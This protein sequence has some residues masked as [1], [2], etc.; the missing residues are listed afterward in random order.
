MYFF[1]LTMLSVNGL[2]FRRETGYISRGFSQFFSILQSKFLLC[3]FLFH[4]ECIYGF[5]NILRIEGNYF[6]KGIKLIVVTETG[7]VLF[8]V[9][10]ESLNIT[11]ISFGFH[12][13][14]LI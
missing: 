14:K 10:T 4:T 1:Y 8:D 12:V 11:C 13:V 5:N 9:R 2:K 6:P 7:F 3:V